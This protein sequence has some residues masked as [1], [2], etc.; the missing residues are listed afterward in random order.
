MISIVCVRLYV[1][2]TYGLIF[3]TEINFHQVR[4][5]NL[6]PVSCFVNRFWDRR[7]D[8]VAIS[9]ALQI[10][11]ILEF[12]WSTDRDDGFFELKAADTYEQHKFVNGALRATVPDEYIHFVVVSR[13]S[14]GKSDFYSK[15]KKSDIQD[16][17]KDRDR[18]FTMNIDFYVFTSTSISMFLRQY[19]T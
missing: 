9:A 5:Y 8:W 15:L 3:A 16:G 7:L 17:K 6:D 12:K 19:C 14:A 4:Q 11:C 2:F 13:R 10:E 18:L 1:N